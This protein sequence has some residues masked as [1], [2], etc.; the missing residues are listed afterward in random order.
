MINLL[1]IEDK[2]INKKDYL[3]RLILVI[4][5]FIFAIIVIV[6]V[7]FL[8]VFFSLF[9]EEKDLSRQLDI[10]KAGSGSIETEKIY[11]DLNTLNDRLSFYEKNNE[12]V[13]Q[14]STLFDRIISSKSSGVKIIYLKYEKSKGDTIT[15]MGKSG[16]RSDFV[17]FKK[18]I[19]DD[20]F[21]S[22]VSSPLSNLLKET[23][24]NFTM[25]IGL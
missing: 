21:F 11:T 8:P 23:D 13:R 12:D 24:I 22:I 6:F 16:N 20:D 19:E 18:R 1:P 17:D 2:I 25:T 9:F 3:S 7:L 15:I 10:I 5:F 4:G 14:I